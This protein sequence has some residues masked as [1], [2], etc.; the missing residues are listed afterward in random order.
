VKYWAPWFDPTHPN[1]AKEGELRWFTTVNGEDA[2]VDGP[3]P[4]MIGGEPIMARSRTF[5][6]SRLSDNPDLARTGYSS[7][8]AAL[9][10]ELR[11]AYR[12]GDFG[13]GLK[14]GDWQVIP[15][16]WVIAAQE[17][18]RADGWH[19]LTMTAMGLDIGAGRDETVLAA[20]FGA[21]FA[22]LETMKGDGARELA[23][24]AGLVVLNRR[25]NCPVVVD[26]G[27]GFGGASLMLFKEN[28]ISYQEFNGAAA[29]HARTADG[30]L[31]FFNKR[32]EAWWKFRESLNPEQMGGSIVALP[33]D[34]QLR[35]DLT[36]PAWKLTTRG[37]QIESKEDIKKRLG[38]SPDRGDACVMCLSEGE[39]A[40]VRD[41]R[42]MS[43]QSEPQPVVGYANMKRHRQYRAR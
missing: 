18:W 9:P 23:H 22:P 34:P 38:R 35:A 32:A 30:R 24:A 33:P 10:D 43:G 31:Q 7:V 20:R 13:V 14:D 17:R 4:H 28:G 27:G 11:R 19:G 2:E 15:T 29:S 42:R 25:N 36:A 1:P 16:K 3:G 8:L 39:R 37:I 40:A 21:W 26:V 6:R 5:I 41:L 12:D